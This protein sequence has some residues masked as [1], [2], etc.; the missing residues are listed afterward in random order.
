MNK[1]RI[2]SLKLNSRKEP[3]LYLVREAACD[4]ARISEPR[5]LYKLFNQ[6][7]DLGNLAEEHVYVACA[8]TNCE[9][10]AVFELS[11]GDSSRSI[12]NPAAIITRALLCGANCIF[13]THNHPSGDCTPSSDDKETCTRIS[14]ACSICGLHLMDF[15]VQSSNSYYSFR[16]N[17]LLKED[18]YD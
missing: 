3:E 18:G 7:F 17:N 2:Y 15:I 6:L 8:N 16:E 1:I 9:V 10:L 14:K 12:V 4:N 11:H 5:L 13:I